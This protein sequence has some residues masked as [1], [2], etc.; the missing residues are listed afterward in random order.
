MLD[1]LKA[2]LDFIDYG[3]SDLY[4]AQNDLPDYDGNSS[5]RDYMSQAESYIFNAKE[6]LEKAISE[7][8]NISEK[9]GW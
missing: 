8:E 2:V 6:A 7:L 3:H 5:S 1:K 9:L 4:S